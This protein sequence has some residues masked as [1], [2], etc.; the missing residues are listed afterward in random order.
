MSTLKDGPANYVSK[1]TILEGFVMN[2][3]VRN[4]AFIPSVGKYERVTTTAYRGYECKEFP[5]DGLRH[6]S[7]DM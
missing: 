7:A 6:A 3:L 2:F 1:S 4:F 5:V